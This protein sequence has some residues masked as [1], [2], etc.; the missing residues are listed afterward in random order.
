MPNRE[1]ILDVALELLNDAGTGPISTNHIAAAAGISPGNLY[2]HFRNK[3]QIVQ[4]LF[5][6]LFETYERVFVLPELR[7]PGYD[8]GADRY[9]LQRF[10][11]PA[12]KGMI[13]RSGR[14]QRQP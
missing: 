12:S 8:A 13:A 11:G 9:L 10:I 5:E 1:R 4:T 6:R 3:E 2:C 7:A 14:L